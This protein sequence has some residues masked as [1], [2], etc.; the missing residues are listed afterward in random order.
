MEHKWFQHN[1]RL[2]D[3]KNAWT[4]W[5]LEQADHGADVH[6]HLLNSMVNSPDNDSA[7]F[8]ILLNFQ[9]SGEACISSKELD[10]LYRP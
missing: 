10:E 9:M 1:K 2:Q 7:F 6:D 5:D 3:Q 8:L 4:F